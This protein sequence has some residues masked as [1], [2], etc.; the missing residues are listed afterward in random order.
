MSKHTYVDL[1]TE[2]RDVLE[3][4]I[5]S[6]NAPARTQTRARILLLADRS[7]GPQRA[8]QEIAVA[9][10]C[11][12]GTVRNVRHRFQRDGLQAALHD[13][14]RPGQKPKITGEIEAQLTVLACSD[15]PAGHARWTL[16]LLADKMIELGHIEYVSHVTIGEV[17]KK[18]HSSHGK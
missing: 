9:L 2:Q 8:D 10:L 13:K 1:T 7:Q 12:K 14:P 18:T 6:G 16:R 3:Q 15:P 4:L 11:H 5:H 17:L